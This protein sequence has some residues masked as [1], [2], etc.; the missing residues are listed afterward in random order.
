M[1]K[2]SKLIK[3]IS[4]G[5][6]GADVAGLKAAEILKIPTG[7]TAPKG[8][9][10]ENGNDLTLKTR[11]GLTESSTND[12]KQRTKDNIVNS[13][14]T[15]IFCDRVSP[16]SI[17]TKK[18]CSE[19]RKP[20]VINPSKEYFLQWLE[21]NKINVLNVAGNRESVSPGIET[22]TIKFLTSTLEGAAE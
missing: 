7:G 17:L 12:Y 11:F 13:D 16:G 10:T 19:L 14:G 21:E 2:Y 1:V 15:V 9:K 22:K 18:Y 4:G 20:C 3:V 8:F 6:T 5:Q